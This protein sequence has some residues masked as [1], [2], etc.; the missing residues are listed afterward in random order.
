MAIG[1]M[2]IYFLKGMLPWQYENAINKIHR[3]KK[4]EHMKENITPNSLVS[5]YPKEFK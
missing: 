1:F 4:I 2:L 5:G 3:F